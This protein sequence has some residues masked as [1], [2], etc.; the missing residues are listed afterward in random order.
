MCGIFAVIGK[1]SINTRDFFRDSLVVGTIRGADSTGIFADVKQQV[2]IYKKAMAGPD[3]LQMKPAER[4]I[5]SA[6]SFLVGHHRA[7]TRG[8]ITNRNAHPFTSG[9]ITL[10]HNGTLSYVKNSAAFDV[11]SEALCADIADRGGKAALEDAMGAFAVIWHDASTGLISFARNSERPLAWAVTK[12]GNMLLGSELG[13]IT[14]LAARNNMDVSK[15]GTLPE[16]VI[17]TVDP[18]NLT[19]GPSEVKLASFPKIPAGGYT[20]GKVVSWV[21]GVLKDLGYTSQDIPVKFLKF[22]QHAVHVPGAYG[23]RAYGKLIGHTTKAP[24]HEVEITGVTYEQCQPYLNGTWVTHIT[25]VAEPHSQDPRLIAWSDSLKDLEKY[26]VPSKNKSGDFTDAKGNVIS[27]NQWRKLVKG[28]CA[29]CGISF[30]RHDAKTMAFLVEDESPICGCCA[31][32]L[33]DED[34]Q[35]A[36][37]SV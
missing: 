11:D 22:R 6:E 27:R 2:S 32:T 10:V 21:K 23:N 29:L 1:Q 4:L 25:H 33:N 18:S 13:M 7:A 30:S 8:V 37:T 9:D 20:S 14:W 12:N 26:V 36:N 16:D 24:Y 31:E 34:I 35:H 19:A 17:Y 15:S 28:G 5:T 3:F